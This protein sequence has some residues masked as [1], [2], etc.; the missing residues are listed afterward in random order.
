MIRITL[1][2]VALSA[3]NIAGAQQLKYIAGSSYHVKI[4]EMLKLT[5]QLSQVDNALTEPSYRFCTYNFTEI[6]QKVNPDGSADISSTLDSFTTKIYVAKVEDRNEFFR[7]NSNIEGDLANRLHDPRA[8]PRAQYLG[9]S[10]K[11][12]LDA[13]G[14]VKNFDNLSAFQTATISH[15]YDYDMM[16]AMMSFAD[17]LRIGQLLE[18]SNGAIAAIAAGGKTSLPYTLTEIHVTKNMTAHNTG[19]HISYSAIF[20]NP[21]DNLDYL[22]GISFPIN[23]K[24]FTGSSSGT[25]DLANG[26][27]TKQSETDSAEMD[28]NLETDIIHNSIYRTCSLTR[29]EN[30]VLR[31]IDLKIRELPDSI[32]S[33]PQKEGKN[34]SKPSQNEPQIEPILAPPKK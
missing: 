12:T 11:Y 15:S 30:K 7:F 13:N 31:G 5:Q 2:L 33:I 20:T 29:T 25:I 3:A 26:I 28:L 21:P 9:Q 32:K 23:L 14:L 10:L 19:D 22:E 18:Q 1:L 24:N 4:H 17:S 34:T 16:H 6:V 27:I 8:L